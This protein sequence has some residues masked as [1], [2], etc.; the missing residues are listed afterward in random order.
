MSAGFLLGNPL[1]AAVLV[2]LGEV[3]ALGPLDDLLADEHQGDEDD[4]DADEDEPRVMELVCELAVGAGGEGGHGDVQ[5]GP[6]DAGGS[7][8]RQEPRYG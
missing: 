1:R 3:L 8:P 5:R 6:D 7:R 2:V 4:D